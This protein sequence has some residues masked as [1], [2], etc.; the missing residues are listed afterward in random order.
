MSHD[1]SVL[2]DPPSGGA[3][4]AVPAEAVP[5]RGGALPGVNYVGGRAYLIVAGQCAETC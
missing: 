3:R 5:A 1:K 2:G 4:S